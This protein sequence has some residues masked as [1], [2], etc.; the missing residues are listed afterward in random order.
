[1]VIRSALERCPI[2]GLRQGR[3]K[4]I[5]FSAGEERSDTLQHEIPLAGTDPLPNRIQGLHGWGDCTF[6]P[7]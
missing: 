4:T 7:D 3:P 2:D 1:M 5:N 6:L